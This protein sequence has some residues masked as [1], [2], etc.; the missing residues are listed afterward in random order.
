MK[1]T[2]NDMM[3]EQTTKAG[4]AISH[5]APSRVAERERESKNGYTINYGCKTNQFSEAL[6]KA[7][8]ANFP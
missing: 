4:L 5:T 2:Q 3:E 1:G 6:A 8:M 7:C